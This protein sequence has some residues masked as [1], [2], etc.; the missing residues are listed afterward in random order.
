MYFL[1]I[2]YEIT[3]GVT[4]WGGPRTHA[5]DVHQLL[6]DGRRSIHQRRVHDRRLRKRVAHNSIG[7][8]EDLLE[9]SHHPDASGRFQQKAHTRRAEGHGCGG[10][11]NSSSCTDCLHMGFHVQLGRITHAGR[12]LLAFFIASQIQKRISRI[13]T[14]AHVQCATIVRGFR[15]GQERLQ[16]HLDLQ[17]RTAKGTPQQKRGKKDIWLAR[18]APGPAAGASR[19]FLSLPPPHALASLRSGQPAARQ[20]ALAATGYQP[21]AAL[22]GTGNAQSALPASPWHP[23]A[24]QQRLAET[25]HPRMP[26]HVNYPHPRS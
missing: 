14:C 11:N 22:G 19:A 1:S 17:S 16:V 6:T 9:C 2:Y 24:P 4:F 20:P 8:A 21:G 12:L 25:Q 7:R 15:G 10:L 23:P 18:R 5:S 3:K 13:S 26:G